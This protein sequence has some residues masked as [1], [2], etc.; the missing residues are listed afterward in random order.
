MIKINDKDWNKSKDE[1]KIAYCESLL[2][3]VKGAREKKDLEW[4]LN[5]MFEE[6]NHYLSYNTTTKSIEANPPRRRGEVRMV[7]NKVKSSKR[8]IQNYLI[9]SKPKW[10]V[11]PGDIDEDTVV[12]ARKLGKTMDYIFQKLHLESMIAGV[13]D[14]GLSTS[15]GWVEV[16]W[17]PEAEKGEGQVRVRLHDPFDVWVDKR[18]YLY[19][20]KLVSNFV[21]KTLS[22][23]EHE[24]KND[25]RY[26]EKAR[27]KVKPD[28]EK[29]VSR[30]KAKILT[31][32]Y[33]GQ[34]DQVIKRVNVKEFLLW[35][36]E[37]NSKGGNI[38]LFTYAGGQVLREEDLP[39][40]EYPIYLFQI[41]MNPL[42]VYQRAWMSDAIPLNKALDRA[43]SQKI[44]YVNQAL[45]YRIIADKGHGA[46]VISNQAGEIIEINK[47]REFQQMSMNPLPS[48]F[49]S[50]TSDFSTYIEDTL[51]A[52]DAALGRLPAGA[53]SGK[54]LEALQAADANNLTGLTQ[55]LES[56]LSV[57]GSKI[58]EV[59]AD[60]Y[61]TSRIIKIAE[62]EDG[63]DFIRIT[64]ENGKRKSDST[65][66]TKDN[67]LIVKIGSW[68][69]HTREAQRETILQLAELGILPA[70]EVLR[71]FEFPNIDEISSKARDQRL[72]QNQMDLEVAGRTQGGQ[73][74]QEEGDP[75]MVALADKENTTMMGGQELPPTEGADMTHSQG[76][77]DFT[78]TDMF[79]QAP[80]EVQQI[81]I[82]HLQGEMQYHGVQPGGF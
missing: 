34:D 53:R 82:N 49:D 18:A 14:S 55:S 61:V 51:G 2:E 45:V 27:K 13:I 43:L 44:M 67:E 50:L 33:S 22:K 26:D 56:F 3:D 54:T 12:N 29:A 48:G 74:P 65:I 63:Q 6:G 40:T 8:A 75:Q 41:S 70:E 66:V 20:G 78:R 57:V 4:Y 31:K 72:E 39:E 5:Y 52:H 1:E 58:M 79:A 37:K 42:K 77:I 69:G 71:Q 62:P 9:S 47:G 23:A 80:P 68:L 46:A 24:V 16:D 25:E 19:G 81:I 28:E 59:I 17:D 36:N 15:V 32:E 60:K 30:M 7:V 38:K 35:D 64:G 21:A 11:I 10:E 73:A 76:H